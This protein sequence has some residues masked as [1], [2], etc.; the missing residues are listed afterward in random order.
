MVEATNFHK[1]SRKL[2]FYV[3]IVSKKTVNNIYVRPTENY[4]LI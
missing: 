4:L 1:V 2:Y 3:G